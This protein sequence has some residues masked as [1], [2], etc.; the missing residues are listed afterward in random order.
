MI[1]GSPQR[2]PAPPRDEDPARSTEAYQRD[3]GPGNPEC[4][5]WHFH[6]SPPPDADEPRPPFGETARSR[7]ELVL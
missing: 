5:M 4:R 7:G 2:P 6:C 3:D 1:G